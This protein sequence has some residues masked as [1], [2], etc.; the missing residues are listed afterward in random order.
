MVIRELTAASSGSSSILVSTDQPAGSNEYRLRVLCGCVY[1][2][3]FDK[4]V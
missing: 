2:L 3:S 4:M 1:K